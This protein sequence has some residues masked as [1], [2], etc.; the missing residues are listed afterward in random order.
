MHK[1]TIYKNDY[2]SMNIQGFYHEEYCG[3]GNWRI[4]GTIENLITTFKNDIPP[5]KSSQTLKSAILKMGEILK[6]D[7]LGIKQLQQNNL[8]ICV[9]PRAKS[10][11]NYSKD[12]LLFKAT[13]NAV[14][15]QID[16]LE[17]G[18]DY[19]QRYT[20]TRTTHRD[21]SGHGGDG[22][23]PY[24]GITKN[25]CTISEHVKNKHV[26]LI[27]DLY[28]KTINIDEDAI[29]ALLDSGAKSVIFYTPGK[30]VHNCFWL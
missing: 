19:I 3:G 17:N 12:Q 23:R 2:L 10:E 15:S 6:K 13:V 1:F 20:N 8:I 16:G 25:T 14:I 7:L 18:T 28:T 30:T 24:P 29:Q 9:V 5:Y 4:S 22:D 11:R 27:D 21:K 26:L